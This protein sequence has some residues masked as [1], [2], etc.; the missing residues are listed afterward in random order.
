MIVDHVADNVKQMLRMQAATQI[1]LTDINERLI[2]IEN[3]VKSRTLNPSEINDAL[4]PQF[5]PL[6]SIDV[7]KEFDLLLRHTQEAVTQF[8]STY[9]HS[10]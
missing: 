6:T 8:V 10:I 2:K 1:M 3:A 9:K 7:I 5:L 4:I